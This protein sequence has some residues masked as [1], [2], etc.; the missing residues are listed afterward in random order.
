MTVIRFVTVTKIFDHV[1]IVVNYFP[2]QVERVV[3]FSSCA[4]LRAFGVPGS[5]LEYFDFQTCSDYDTW[6]ISTMPVIVDV[7]LLGF[8]NT[9]T[10]H[11]D[12]TDKLLYKASMFNETEWW[13]EYPKRCVLNF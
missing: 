5:L 13:C 1:W 8:S 3:L 9:N 7:E 11:H 10:T 6:F 4:E 12:A 2:V